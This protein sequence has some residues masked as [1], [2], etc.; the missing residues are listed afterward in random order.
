MAVF[1][2]TAAGPTPTPAPAPAPPSTPLTVLPQASPLSR[3]SPT[4][5]GV[6]SGT[7]GSDSATTGR[8]THVGATMGSPL[9]MAPEQWSDAA[10]VG[11]P[12]DLYAL[13]ILCFEA[14]TGQLPFKGETH[15]Q[16]AM[17]HARQP[18]PPLGSGVPALARPRAGAGP[19]QEPGRPVRQ[20]RSS[21]PPRSAARAG[22]RAIR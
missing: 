12:T 3:G 17:A 5:P 21:S 10:A 13:G 8:L 11:P 16:I 7:T 9:Y 14:L 1:A 19:G 2:E 4:P 22:S 20:T 15:M 18:V 6:R